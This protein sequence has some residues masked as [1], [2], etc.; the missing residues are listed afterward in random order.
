MNTISASSFAGVTVSVN[1]VVLPS[2]VNVFNILFDEP[3]P[4][5]VQADPL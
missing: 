2:P 4:T 5:A 3:V 1:V